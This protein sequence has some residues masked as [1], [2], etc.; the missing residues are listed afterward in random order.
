[1][2][3][4]RVA[5]FGFGVVGE[6]FFDITSAKPELG[7]DIRRIVVRDKSKPRP[8][9][10]AILSDANEVWCDP[11]IDVVVELV[12]DSEAAFRICRRAFESG[13][14][15]VSANKKMLAEHL[16][17]ILALQAKHGKT[18]LYEGAVCGSVP[19]MRN[20]SDY[21]SRT[22]VSRM[23]GIVNGSTNY[24]LSQMASTGGSYEH[25]LQLATQAGFAESDPSLDVEGFD[26]VYKLSLLIYQGTGNKVT[27]DHIPRRGITGLVKEDLAF[28][29][30][31]RRQVKLLASYSV[32]DENHIS[33]W[34]APVLI[35]N[36]HRLSEV[37]DEYNGLLVESHW[38]EDQ[39]LSGKG[40]G[41]YP[42]AAAVVSD[43]LSLGNDYAYS[44]SWGSAMAQLGLGEELCAYVSFDEFMPSPELKESQ[45]LYLGK[46]GGRRY[47]ILKTRIGSLLESGL[48][49]NIDY[50]LIIVEDEQELSPAINWRTA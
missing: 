28:A 50:S 17:E 9:P 25:V 5:L 13:K 44:R 32:I 2:R 39:F 22:G 33:A 48:F 45:V 6:G 30:Q 20:L 11:A 21:F 31:Q 34:V 18:L 38:A 10:A 49:S 47:V 43:V 4:L 42:T 15:V 26:A 36:R 40:A 29:H 12:D 16:T 1:M 46:Q 3:K 8:I 35:G 37:S 41:R 27:A 7:I 19:V 24:I 14:H 23:T